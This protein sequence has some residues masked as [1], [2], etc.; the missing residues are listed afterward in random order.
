MLLG[1]ARDISRDGLFV[2]LEM[3][4]LPAHSLAQL[5]IPTEDDAA[6]SCL[7]IPVAIARHTPE[8]VGL[9]YWSDDGNMLKY[10]HS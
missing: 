4:D 9:L 10:V 2:E 5:L 3:T 7:R 8:G 1:W 6:G